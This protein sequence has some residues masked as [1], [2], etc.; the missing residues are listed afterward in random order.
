MYTSYM[1]NVYIC[2]IKTTTK[3]IHLKTLQNEKET[4]LQS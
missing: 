4:N 2:S 1:I 3:I